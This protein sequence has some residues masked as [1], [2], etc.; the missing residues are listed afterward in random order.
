MVQSFE[1]LYLLMQS[2]HLML[3][4]DLGQDNAR[5]LQQSGRVKVLIQFSTVTVDFV[6]D[7][8][9][10]MTLVADGILQHILQN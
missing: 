1:K 5:V 6:V 7:I 2:I 9:H 3:G 10:E 4:S 8:A